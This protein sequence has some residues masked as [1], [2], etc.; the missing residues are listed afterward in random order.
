MNDKWKKNLELIILF[1]M[2]PDEAKAYK[3]SLLYQEISKQVFPNHHH[4]VRQ[5]KK[6]SDPRK[7]FLFK[8]CYKLLNETKD[9]LKGNEYKFYIHAQMEVLKKITIDGE[10]PMISPNCL[11]GE[12]A[13]KRWLI[14]KNK[15][16]YSNKKAEETESALS[17]LNLTNKI[18]SELRKTKKVLQEKFQGNINIKESLESGIILHWV[19]AKVISPYFL[20]LSPTIKKW[21]KEKE[22]SYI[23]IFSIDS[24]IYLKDITPDIENYFKELF[25]NEYI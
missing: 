25:K 19:S 5:K 13:W 17:N 11:L 10:Y 8:C 23:E 12:K 24:L 1:K 15:F 18:K 22:T 2:T 14:W 7:T 20:I 3:L 9:K 6:I 4:L 21:I 16:N